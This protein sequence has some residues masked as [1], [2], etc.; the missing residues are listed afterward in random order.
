M[1]GFYYTYMLVDQ[2]TGSH[3]YVGCTH[4]LEGRMAKHN[5]GAV[6]HTSKYRP[7]VLETAVAFQSKDKAFA[8]ETY[9]KL[10]SGRAFAAKHF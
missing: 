4:D 10:H 9:L 1:T 7:W 8:F 3:R 5:S 6:P 2:A